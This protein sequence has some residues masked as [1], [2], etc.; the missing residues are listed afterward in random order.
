MT[1]MSY[2]KLRGLAIG[3]E[4]RTDTNTSSIIRVLTTKDLHLVGKINHE[5]FNIL[6]G[7]LPMLRLIIKLQ[8]APSNLILQKVFA[9]SPDVTVSLLQCFLYE[10]NRVRVHYFGN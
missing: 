5:I 3:Y 2:K 6:N 9:A 7:C 8:L 4:Y 10:N 1:P